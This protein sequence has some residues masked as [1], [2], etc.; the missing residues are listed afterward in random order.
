MSVVITSSQNPKIKAIN[1]LKRKEA[2]KPVTTKECP[3]CKSA[4]NIK[5]TRCPNCTSELK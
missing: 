4:I 1:K 2:P 5:A 3:F